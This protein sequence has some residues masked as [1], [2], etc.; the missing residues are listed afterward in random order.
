MRK[1]YLIMTK[2]HKD[3]Y[4]EEQ[5]SKQQYTVYRPL[6]K[7][8][9]KIKNKNKKITESLFPRYLFIQLDIGLDDWSK[10]RSTKG[11]LNIIRFGNS[12]TEVP[13]EII[14]LLK[15]N[16]LIN[17]TA[18]KELRRFKYGDKI[19]IKDGPFSGLEALFD[20]Y[21]QGG[22]RIIV[23]FNMLNKMTSLN[24]SVDRVKK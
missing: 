7:K 5:L 12:F 3:A 10:V 1:W 23:L 13:S 20:R 15:E 8:Q 22:D 6:I 14:H 17:R 11:V 24:L 21:K 2:H 18:S 16:E 4:A 9:K 19:T